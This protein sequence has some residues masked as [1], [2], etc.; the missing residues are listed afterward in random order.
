MEYHQEDSEDEVVMGGDAYSAQ[1]LE[2]IPSEDL[3]ILIISISTLIPR[4]DNPV[5]VTQTSAAPAFQ[6][7]LDETRV[8]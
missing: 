2:A 6:K 7:V 3:K 8:L 5:D 4:G 1:V